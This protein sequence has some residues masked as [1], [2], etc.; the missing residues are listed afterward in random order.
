MVKYSKEVF[1]Y[2]T[3]GT[4][5]RLKTIRRTDRRWSESY[6][7]GKALE[8][9]IPEVE[10]ELGIAPPVRKAPSDTEKTAAV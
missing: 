6:V 9:F 5:Q 3:P 2:V 10:R 4:K 1:A 7:I 8:K